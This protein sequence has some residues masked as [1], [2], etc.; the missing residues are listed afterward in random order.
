MAEVGVDMVMWVVVSI[1]EIGFV[2]QLLDHG[3][4]SASDAHG[5]RCGFLYWQAHCFSRRLDTS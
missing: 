4:G 2:I 5:F 1:V 3:S